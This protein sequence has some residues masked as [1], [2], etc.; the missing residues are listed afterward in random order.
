MPTLGQMNIPRPKNWDEFQDITLS[1]L[2]LRWRSSNLQQNGRNGQPQ[3]G[4]DIYGPDDLGRPVGV[5]CKLAIES[6]G[7]DIKEIEAEVA[8]AESFVPPLRGFFLAT[9]EP[10]DVKLQAAV[11]V[12]SEARL[13]AQKFPVGV[14]FWDD[15]MDSLTTSPADFKKH[16]PQIAIA[17]QPPG[18]PE[19]LCTLDVAFS[20]N[21]LQRW[22]EL[23]FGEIGALLSNEDP[24]Q[25]EQGVRGLTASARALMSPDAHQELERSC[26][27]IVAACAAARWSEAD[28]LASRIKGIVAAL[29]YSFKGRA[30][31]AFT[32]GR[33][34]AAWEGHSLASDGPFTVLEVEVPK[35]CKLLF[36]GD[37]VAE[38][39]N[40]LI[41]EFN[42]SKSV[43]AV[44]IPNRGYNLVRRKLLHEGMQ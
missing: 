42:T 37:P 28:G 34:F 35:T 39:L 10:R 29:E 40:A 23:I 38:Q 21:S 9:S 20:G 31:A 15:L 27:E 1:A 11:R 43:S 41:V 30:L 25:F 2:K 13:Q 7:A 33:L 18:A 36:P 14:I 44:R 6:E 8:K 4:V 19:L 32:L 17:E 24:M 16:Y 12:L 26:R 22:M 5:Q 3:A